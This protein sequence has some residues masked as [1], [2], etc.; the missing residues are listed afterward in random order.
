MKVSC[1]ELVWKVIRREALALI[2][3]P[4]VAIPASG[5]VVGVN[6]CTNAD[7]VILFSLKIFWDCANAEL[8]EMLTGHA[9]KRFCFQFPSRKKV[10]FLLLHYVQRDSCRASV[11]NFYRFT[12]RF[13][14]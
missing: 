7:V 4:R 5:S 14:I 10:A 11:A 3:I 1:A 8:K 12:K 9:E 13:V 6:A 2:R